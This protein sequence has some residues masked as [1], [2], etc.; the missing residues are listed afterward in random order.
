MSGRN[1]PFG[2]PSKN[3][4]RNKSAAVGGGGYDGKLR[5]S[6][7]PSTRNTRSLTPKAA[8]RSASAGSSSSS[9]TRAAAAAAASSSSVKTIPIKANNKAAA[10]KKMLRKVKGKQPR[11]QDNPSAPEIVEKLAFHTS[12]PSPPIPSPLLSCQLKQ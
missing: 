7:A 11:F 1:R 6:R 8:G 5:N 4:L 9:N 2:R 3:N 10:G 12:L